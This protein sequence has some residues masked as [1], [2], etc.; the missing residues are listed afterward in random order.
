MEIENKTIALLIDSENISQDYF[1]ILMD[2]LNEFGNVTYK[3]IYG[4]FTLQQASG[5]KPL[6]LEF[7]IE[8]IQQFSNTKGKNATDSAMII[9]AMDILHKGNINCVC[10]ATSD[11]DFTKL[12]VR[13]RNENYFV[14]GAGEG[15]TPSSFRAACD[16][17]LLMD[18]L[19]DKNENKS[20]SRS[21]KS[22]TAE[23]IKNEALDKLISMAKEIIKDRAGPDG[24]MHFSTFMNDLYHK[25]NSFNP[26]N[27]G[28]NN[29]PI[30]FFKELKISN[31]KQFELIRK[32][33]FDWI[34]ISG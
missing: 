31:K 20:K 19:M 14:I 18:Q 22:K 7:A 13:F 29:R 21:P 1:K 25:D 8:P 3:R 33:N 23:Q 28:Y 10:L 11:S 4:D 32:N 24:S 34:K 12:A 5:W 9:D 17:F 15:K 16:R 27:Y 2:E 6:L 26:K 30:T